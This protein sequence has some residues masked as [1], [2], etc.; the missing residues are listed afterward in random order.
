MTE[1]HY[2]SNAEPE[3]ENPPADEVSAELQDLR[4]K[5]KRLERDNRMLAIMNENAEKMRVYHEAEKK[6]H[7]LYND[8]LLSNSPNMI[9]LFNEQLCLV[10]CSEACRPLL[11]QARRQDLTNTPLCKIFSSSVAT[12]WVEKI[13]QQHVEALQNGSSLKYDDTIVL[14]DETYVNVQVMIAAIV[15]D[16]GQ[17]YGTIMTLNDVTE[18]IET[19]RKAEDASLSKSSFLANMS[20]EIRTPMNAVKGLSELL[21]LTELNALQRNYV[22]NIISSAN[23]LLGILN[24]VLDFSK[25]DA[26]K[27]EFIEGPYDLAELISS[28][29]NVVSLK[30]DDKRLL[31][32]VDAAPD[33]PKTLNGDD[34]RVKQVLINILSN[35]VKYTNAGFVRLSLWMEHE[36]DVAYLV[37]AIKDTGIGIRAED[38]PQ[39]FDAFSRVD[40]ITNRSIKGTGLGLA[41]SRHLA[42]AMGGN[43]RVESQYGKGSTFTFRIPQKVVDASPMI[44]VMNKSDKRVLLLDV[45]CHME[46][47]EKQLQSLQIDYLPVTAD[48]MLPGREVLATF[49]HCIHDE[50]NSEQ[51]IEILH[52]AIPKC[53][54]GALKNIRHAMAL[55]DADDTVLYLPLFI[56][57][58]A[59]FL[60]KRGR[61][62]ETTDLSSGATEN[63]IVK[64]AKFLVVDDN[65]LNLLVSTEML[66]SFQAEIYSADSGDKAVALCREQVFDLIFM[67]HMMPGKDGIETTREI[68][69]DHERGLNCHSPIIALTA[70]V[71]NDMAEYYL[72]CGM[73][74]FLSKPVSMID[75]GRILLK[76]I[77]AEKFVMRDF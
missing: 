47:V 28:V 1:E 62:P 7:Y 71:V 13:H 72:Q 24:D 57:N 31:M 46:L 32:V 67:D 58:L 39:L 14:R 26:N 25:I 35:A 61:D 18:L 43:I 16:T 76:W 54:F 6:L 19:K 8:L 60:N 59:D 40:L 29:S 10:I 41:I 77:P 42:M 17:R 2:R 9:F 52:N 11:T 33:L 50:S 12:D 69:A 36:A 64:N 73:N 22:T 68:R 70:N 37:C 15:N 5:V 21:V 3:A 27:L 66:K 56:K 63:I 65:D 45:G 53:R 48:Q 23:S 74:D 30:A 44:E 34:V 38:I 51:A 55:S 20:H 49:T 4:L 75:L